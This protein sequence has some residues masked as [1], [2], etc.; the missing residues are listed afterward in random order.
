[1]GRSFPPRPACLRF[2]IFLD[3][4][5][6]TFQQS[7]FRWPLFPHAQHSGGPKLWEDNTSAS[8][9]L[10]C[11]SSSSCWDFPRSGSSVELPSVAPQYMPRTGNSLWR[12]ASWYD[13]SSMASVREPRRDWGRL[14]FSHN[15]PSPSRIASMNC[16][17]ATRSSIS[18][19]AIG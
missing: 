16:S 15:L 9:P 13:S 6:P 17:F 10:T 14:C 12:K 8:S 7:C 4:F 1:M 3:L 11:A 5:P 18:S 2:C 19:R